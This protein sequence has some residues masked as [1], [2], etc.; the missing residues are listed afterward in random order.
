[1]AE[2]QAFHK[3]EPFGSDI[4]DIRFSIFSSMFANYARDPKKS[5]PFKPAD[6]VMSDHIKEKLKPKPQTSAEQMAIVERLHNQFK[7]DKP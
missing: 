3:I 6:F 2:W 5:T 1:M 4:D 7:K